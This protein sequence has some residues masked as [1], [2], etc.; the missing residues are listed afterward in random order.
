LVENSN[1]RPAGQFPVLRAP[2]DAVLQLSRKVQGRTKFVASP[3]VEAELFLRVAFWTWEA[4]S[5][6]E[7]PCPSAGRGWVVAGIH[8]YS[9][10][11]PVVLSSNQSIPTVRTVWA[12]SVPGI[13]ILTGVGCG[14]YDPN[15]SSRNLYLNASAFK[16]PAPF[17]VGNTNTLPN[18]RTCAS[19]NENIAILKNFPIRE[20]IRLEFG[21][22]AFNAFNRHIWGGLTSNIDNPSYGK[23]SSASAPRTVQIHLR[24]QF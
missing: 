10:G 4:L 14:S 17:T 9:A 1:E 19:L 3:N 20:N 6:F 24:V 18:V 21:L 7:Q 23:F 13:P 5:Q 15:D 22:E 12:N 16:A 8:T 2:C 11:T